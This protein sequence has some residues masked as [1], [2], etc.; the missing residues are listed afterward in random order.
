MALDSIDERR[1]GNREEVKKLV[2]N[3]QILPGCGKS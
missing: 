3:D 1:R 2:S